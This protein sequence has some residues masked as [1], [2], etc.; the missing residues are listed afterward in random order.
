MILITGG[1]GF[2]GSNLAELLVGHH[3]PVTLLTRST[4]KARNI[5]SISDKVKV[6]V[7]DVTCDDCVEQTLHRYRPTVIFHF[8]GQL[9]SYE[10]FA[11]P[12]YDVDV[13]AR[14]TLALL[15]AIR[16]M[17]TP[18]R[19][20]LGST[21]WVIGQHD[22]LA[23]D[24]DTP[25]N[26]RNIYAAN[27]LASEHY[28]RIYY[29]VYDTDTVVLRFTNTFGVREQY[30][31][32]QKAALNYLLYQGYKG[33]DVTIYGEGKTLRDYVYVSDTVSAAETVMERGHAGETYMVGTGVG[34]WFYDIGKWIAELTG[35]KIEYIDP[36]DFHTRIDVGDAVVDN[37]KLRKLGWDWKVGVREGLERTLKYYKEI[38]A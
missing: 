36:P 34:T 16:R 3:Y 22:K 27:R 17:E 18:C 20:I 4:R 9:T 28:C 1:L 12:L 15:E 30:D 11:D 25:C 23:V 14:A 26:P 8:A 38:G 13:N 6:E 24:E 5:E 7:G 10:S 19:F 32:K 35:S 21:F 33:R 2:L 37:R 29:D 31:N